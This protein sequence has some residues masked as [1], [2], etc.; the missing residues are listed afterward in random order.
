MILLVKTLV[1][2]TKNPLLY[3][4]EDILMLHCTIVFLFSDAVNR[5]W[6]GYF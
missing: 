3:A 4:G 1:L 5:M 2:P 6:S